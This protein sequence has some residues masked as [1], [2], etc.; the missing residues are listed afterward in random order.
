MRNNPI[1]IFDSGVGG[2]SVARSIRKVLPNEDIIYIADSYHAPYGSKSEEFIINRSSFIIDYLISQ[3]VK[4][5]VVACNTA[6]VNAIYRLRDKYSIPIIG[7]EPGIKPAVE[8][9]KSGTIGVLATEQTINSSAFKNLLNNFIDQACIETQA[10]PG[11]V[12]L[13][14]SQQLEGHEIKSI[15]KKYTA[16]MLDKGVDTF[17]MGCTHFAFLTETLSEIIGSELKII[18]TYKAVANETLRRLQI[19]ELLTSSIISGDAKFFSSNIQE[20][21]DLLFEKLWGK[22]VTVRRFIE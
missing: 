4:T 6:T 20:N 5:I 13:V 10:C 11:L 1:G 19:N 8:I 3:K 9:S 12:E 16:P 14:E 7:V 2:L 18:N 15:L 22:P 21:T 17:V